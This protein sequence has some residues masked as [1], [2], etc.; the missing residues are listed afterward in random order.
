MEKTL[1]ESNTLI[2]YSS[3]GEYMEGNSVSETYDPYHHTMRPSTGVYSVNFTNDAE[4][5]RRAESIRL[6]IEWA[7]VMNSI[8]KD[9]TNTEFNNKLVQ[10]YNFIQTALI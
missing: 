3:F 4:Y 2:N 10:F 1:Q 5:N 6:T 7:R 9:V 8:G